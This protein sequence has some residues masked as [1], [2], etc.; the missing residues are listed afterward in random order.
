MPAANPMENRKIFPLLVSMSVPPIISMMIQ[1]LYNIVDS[2]FVAHVSQD[3]LTAVS[4]VYPLQNI[5]L[6]LAVGLGV[7]LNACIARNLGAKRSKEAGDAAVHGLLCTAVHS[8]L[9]VIVGLFASEPFLRL[10]TQDEE[11]LSLGCQYAVI[12]ICFSFGSLFHICIEKMF[13]ATGNMVIPMFLQALGAVVNLILD[14]ILIFGWMGIP[15]MG[16]TGAAVATIIGQMIAC[17]SAILLFCKTNRE[18]PITLRGFRLQKNI[19]RQLYSVAIPST[20][21]MAMPSFMVGLLNRVLAGFSETAVNV[22]GIYFKIQSFTYMPSNGLI[23]G[24]RPIMSFNYGAGNLQ[25]MQETFR[26]SLQIVFVIMTAGMLLFL[27]I[28]ELLLSMFAADEALMQMGIPAL[29]IISISF[30]LSSPAV[31]I[32]GSFEA[33]GFGGRSLIVTML[34]QLLIIPPLSF[35]LA[36][37]L[38]PVGVWVTFPVAELIASVVAIWL[39]H[40]T[41]KKILSQASSKPLTTSGEFSS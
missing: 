9:F 15:A 35:L 38:G 18:I 32:A 1:G 39:Y 17:L 3:A 7:G 2:I 12:V 14:P 29:R 6:S 10:F 8:V 13:Q 37:L 27:A 30:F 11:I 5:T 28:P 40:H 23:Q 33:L 22:L 25:R 4:L 16:V 36:P 20:L 19:F 34:R 26:R 41:S 24:M 31:I 21:V